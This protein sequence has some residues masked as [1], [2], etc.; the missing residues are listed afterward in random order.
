MIENGVLVAHPRAE[1]IRYMDAGHV[2]GK[3]VIKVQ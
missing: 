1:T 2:G 3:I